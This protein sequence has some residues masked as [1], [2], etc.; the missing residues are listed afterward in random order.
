MKKTEGPEVSLGWYHL[1]KSRLYKRLDGLVT[2][3][4]FSAVIFLMP[5]HPQHVLFFDCPQ[6]FQSPSHPQPIIVS[7]STAN[8]VNLR[9][10]QHWWNHCKSALPRVILVLALHFLMVGWGHI[11]VLSVP[12]SITPGS[13]GW[14]S[15][16][17]SAPGAAAAASCCACP[18]LLISSVPSPSLAKKHPP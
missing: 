5:L 17:L 13:P 15:C 4:A 16:S 14:M 11:V 7:L 6:F 10:R 18:E 1:N 9:Q 8:K 12:P 2:F 3:F